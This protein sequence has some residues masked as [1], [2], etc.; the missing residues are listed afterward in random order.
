M[1]LVSELPASSGGP[2]GSMIK[3]SRAVRR[4]GL[5]RR[6]ERC[7]LRHEPLVLQHRSDL[8]PRGIGRLAPSDHHRLS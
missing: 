6:D 2:S 8:L 5:Q 3:I 4:D 7:H 1:T